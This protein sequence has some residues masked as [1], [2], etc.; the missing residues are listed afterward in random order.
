MQRKA[1]QSALPEPGPADVLAHLAGR[2]SVSPK[3]LIEPAPG[4]EELL[5]AAA[6]AL[7]APDHEALRPYRFVRIDRAQRARLGQLFALGA[8]RRGC[9]DAEVERARARAFNGPAL[10]A[11]IGR[12]RDG[13][14][15]VPAREQWLCAGAALMNFLNALHLMG[16]GAKVLGGTSVYD[17]EV[18][19]GLCGT[20]ETLLCWI[21]AGTPTCAAHSRYS[22]DP[23]DVFSE[24]QP[25]DPSDPPPPAEQ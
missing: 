13:A 23:A 18:Q 6:L 1:D 25:A 21:V 2:Y 12:V 4:R 20:G 9:D 17:A 22:D 24:W 8:R 19:Q 16:Y 15:G 3:H 10:L 14:Q 5:R 11:L 7:R